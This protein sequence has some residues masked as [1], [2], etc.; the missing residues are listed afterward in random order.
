MT[1]ASGRIPAV[2]GA[3]VLG[4]AP[5]GPPG[6]LAEAGVEALAELYPGWRIWADAAGWHAARRGD[7]VQVY[8]DGAPAFYV[9]ARSATG[10]AGQLRW[11]QA[12][13]AHAPSGCSARVAPG[14]G[15]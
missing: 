11:Q 6:V 4:G 14:P 9:S 1:A 3:P 8:H 15:A 7:F 5:A 10:L 13:Q 2:A 12:A